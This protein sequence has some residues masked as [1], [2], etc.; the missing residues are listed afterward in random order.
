MS[1]PSK[2]S[3]REVEILFRVFVD[4]G[5]KK[6]VNLIRGQTYPT[7]IRDDYSRYTWMNFMSH[8][9]DGADTFANILS[10]L[11]IEEIPPEVVMVRSDDRGEFSEGKFGKL[12]KEMN[13]K[14]EIT[15]TADTLEY[16]GVE[17]RRL[18]R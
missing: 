11:R 13:I 2:T 5:G 17:E 3:N 8:S 7:V 18:A 10:D 14:Q 1:I 6:H 4:L 15:K 12:F 16:N 9:S